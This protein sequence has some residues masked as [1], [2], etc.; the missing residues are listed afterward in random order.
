M[1]SESDEDFLQ[2]NKNYHQHKIMCLMCRSNT[3]S[4]IVCSEC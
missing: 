1:T 2:H 4:L 3:H